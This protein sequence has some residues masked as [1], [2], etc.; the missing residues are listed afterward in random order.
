MNNEIQTLNCDNFESFV[1]DSILYDKMLLPEDD[2]IIF[3]KFNGVFSKRVY[4]PFC[5]SESIFKFS[6]EIISKS[7]YVRINYKNSISSMGFNSEPLNN[8]GLIQIFTDLK[9]FCTYNPKH[10]LR[11][12]FVTDGN[13]IVKIGQYPKIADIK[14]PNKNK[15]DKLL[16]SYAIE[17][18]TSLQ[19]ASSGVGIGAFV[20]LRRVFEFLIDET[21]KKL[22]DKPDWDED[23]YKKQSLK[24][25]IKMCEKLIQIFPDEVKQHKTK[26]YKVLSLGIH[27][28]DEYECLEIYPILKYIIERILDDKLRE[29]EDDMKLKQALKQLEIK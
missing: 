22:T 29:K 15:Y 25:K 26:I 6:E 9:F 14:Y 13:Y 12:C 4:C 27:E 17:Y 3:E 2:K 8:Q 24:N 7:T 16:G 11:F 18:K 28:Q 20:Y 10:V 1:F 19:V 21:H 5:S 23:A